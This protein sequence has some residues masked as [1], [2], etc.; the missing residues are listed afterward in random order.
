MYQR[1]YKSNVLK[2]EKL[3]KVKRPFPWK[4]LLWTL[5]VVALVVGCI[6]LI[7]TP[8]FQVKHVVVTGTEVADPND[9]V[10]YVND[11]MAGKYLYILPK[12][13]ILLTPT[14]TLSEKVK[15]AFPR[16]KSAVV[17]RASFDTLS[18][19]INEYKGVYLWCSELDENQ[20]NNNCSFMDQNGVVF[21]TAPYFSGSAYL[22]LYGDNT[23]ANFPFSPLGSLSLANVVLL[24]A[25]FEAINITATEFHFISSHKLVVGFAH[26]D[27]D[28]QIIF[29]PSRDIEDELSALYTGLRTEP[30][31]SLYHNQSKILEYIDVRFANKVVYKFQ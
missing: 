8:R 30:L 27:R 24:T 9:V 4:R 16:F 11:R 28:A 5:F 2:E 7:K 22:K 3:A 1:T 15:K 31:G 19:S 25:R 13:S 10:K 12:T 14:A 18:V 20:T 29:D 6:T 26:N 23:S 21:A 17:R